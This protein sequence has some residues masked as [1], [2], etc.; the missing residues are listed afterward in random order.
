MKSNNP[1]HRAH[2]RYVIT[3]IVAMVLYIALLFTSITL[4]HGGLTG[5]LRLLVA[6]LPVPPIIVVFIAVLQL[7]QGVDEFERRILI[8]SL[9]LAAGITAI[10]SVTYGFLENAGFPT[11]SAWWTWTAVMGSW[12]ISSLILR[13]RYR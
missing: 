2:R 13:S 1:V 10:L 11:L 9:A 12:F 5:I 3:L 7:L 6:L 8:E 4:L